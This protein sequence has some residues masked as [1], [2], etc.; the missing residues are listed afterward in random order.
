MT[1]P[2]EFPIWFQKGAFVPY[3]V[4]GEEECV[5]S[6]SLCILPLIQVHA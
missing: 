3:S 2:L 5:P 6:L 4:D 1:S